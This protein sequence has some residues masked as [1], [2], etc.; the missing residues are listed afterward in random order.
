MRGRFREGVGAYLAGIE[1]GSTTA[2]AAVT[3]WEWGAMVVVE[4]KGAWRGRQGMV[5]NAHIPQNEG[6]GKVGTCGWWW[7]HEKVKL[8]CHTGD[9]SYDKSHVFELAITILIL[10]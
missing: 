1:L 3:T 6:R 10:Y 5:V 9:Y 8:D 2:A 7:E 4:R